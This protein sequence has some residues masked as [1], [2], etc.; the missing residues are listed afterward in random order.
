MEREY[1]SRRPRRRKD[2]GEPLNIL[3][4]IS[5]MLMYAY[6]IPDYACRMLHCGGPFRVHG[7]I[8]QRGLYRVGVGGTNIFCYIGWGVQA[9]TRYV[10]ISATRLLQILNRY[11]TTSQKWCVTIYI[12][13]SQN[14][15]CYNILLSTNT[16]Y[17]QKQIS[18]ALT[19][20]SLT[21]G[22]FPVYFDPLLSESTVPQWDLP[23]TDNVNLQYKPYDTATIIY[24][25][26]YIQRFLYNQPQ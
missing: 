19:T 5:T 20:G 18:G 21:M 10:P 6:N 24:S 17:Y 1:N 4:C 26:P 11:I 15:R 7:I 22:G 16:M 3:V 2:H 12:I 9:A 23:H 25:H 8:R 14:M 13:M